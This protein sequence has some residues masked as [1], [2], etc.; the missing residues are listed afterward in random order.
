MRRLAVGV[1]SA[2]WVVPL[3]LA[4][5]EVRA[6]VERDWLYRVSGKVPIDSFPHL[7][8]AEVLLWVALVWFGLVVAVW[9]IFRLKRFGGQVMSGPTNTKGVR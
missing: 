2:L 6:F 8:F 3:G 4:A 5:S 9:A 7:R 1:F